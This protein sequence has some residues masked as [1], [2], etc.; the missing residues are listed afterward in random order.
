MASAYNLLAAQISMAIIR[1]P[2]PAAAGVLE[3]KSLET[4]AAGEVLR[5][6]PGG[7]PEL[8]GADLLERCGFMQ[9]IVNRAGE[10]RFIS[11]A[12]DP[13]GCGILVA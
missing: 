5:S 2:A 11:G 12:H 13:L 3:I 7:R 10:S 4:H 6:I 1:H 8:R 9:G